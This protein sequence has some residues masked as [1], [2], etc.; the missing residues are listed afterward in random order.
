MN[1]VVDGTVAALV[2]VLIQTLFKPLLEVW[3]QP[4]APN[5]DTLVRALALLLG[6]A[7]MAVDTLIGGPWPA[8]GNSWL[9]LVGSGALSGAS[10]IGI[11]HL[12]TGSATPPG[13]VSGLP[14]PIAM[15]Q[16]IR[17]DSTNV[18]PAPVVIQPAPPTQHVV[19]LQIAPTPAAP[20]ARIID[21]T[22]VSGGEA[23][24]GKL[25]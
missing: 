18:K 11:Y 10:A 2:A 19:T 13:T 25:P 12:L 15:A 23:A 20:D 7:L 16:T 14:V 4:T 6:V 24:A 3:V 17:D 21:I 22:P 9:L 8:T 1:F 5:H